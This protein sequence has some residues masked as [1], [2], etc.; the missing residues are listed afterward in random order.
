[1]SPSPITAEAPKNIILIGFMGCG[2]STV[3]RAISQQ[4][5]YPLLDTDHYIEE[6][7][8]SK[9]SQIFQ[10]HGES[11][12][13]DLETDLVT[14]LLQKDIAKQIISTGGGL[15]LRKINR[16]ILKSLGYVV[17]LKAGAD[18]IH[19][20]TSKTNHRPL[21]QSK[22]PKVLIHQMLEQRN[23]IYEDCAH[24]TIQTDDLPIND[25][26]HGI[27]ESARYFFSSY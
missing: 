24:L 26:V 17:W 2:K 14:Q 22:D 21:L 20:R 7:T 27:I 8:G 25:T 10:Q 4:L 12:F 9:I 19:E 1:M 3:G 5:N 11:Y 16:S 23:P 18:C 13:R 6:Q 15:P